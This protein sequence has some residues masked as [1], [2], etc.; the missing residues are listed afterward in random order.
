MPKKPLSQT[1]KAVNVL[2]SLKNIWT[3]KE[4]RN[5]HCARE[6]HPSASEEVNE[7]GRTS[8]GQNCF[9][10]V[11]LMSYQ[12][13]GIIPDSRV[14]FIMLAQRYF[15]IPVDWILAISF[16]FPFAMWKF[17]L[18]LS[19]PWSM[20]ANWSMGGVERTDLHVF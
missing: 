1:T 3:Q 6:R 18:K 19:S 10:R 2:K 13:T 9:Q 4:Q 14:D 16:S 15:R 20:I 12:R 7:K 11:D 8:R 17:L 5:L